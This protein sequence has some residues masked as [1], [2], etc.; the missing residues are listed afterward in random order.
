[1][2]RTLS[3][4]HV[5]RLQPDEWERYRDIRL[6]ALAESP[7]AFGSTH[8]R[9]M[10]FAEQTWRERLSANCCVVA[11]TAAAGLVENAVGLAGG[12]V[13]DGG[14]E[15]VSMWVAPEAR[16]QRVADA[17]ITAVSE[18]AA[19]EGHLTLALWV[20]EGN[21]VAERVY[22]RSRFVRTGRRQPV[23][24]GAP[25]MEF[26]MVRLLGLAEADASPPASR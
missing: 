24:E 2:T 1:M 25:A 10:Q 4:I 26:E 20:V 19:Q 17:L 5:R 7:E 12:Y 13:D 14:P 23:R 21:D 8:A 11:F 3:E 6:R 18:W 16:G 15:L 22:A 9:E